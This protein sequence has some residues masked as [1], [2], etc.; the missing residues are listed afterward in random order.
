MAVIR[1]D[2][3]TQEAQNIGLWDAILETA[4]IGTE[5]PYADEVEV[6]ILKAKRS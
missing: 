2:D 6:E 4:G 3:L 5:S 1:K